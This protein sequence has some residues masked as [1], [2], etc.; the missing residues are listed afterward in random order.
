LEFA[1]LVLLGL[2]PVWLGALIRA[3][4]GRDWLEYLGGYL[5]GG[6][7]LLLA[8][9]TVGPLL[10]LV[11]AS[12]FGARKGASHFPL[13]GWYVLAIL[14]VCISSAGLFGFKAGHENEG[15]LA[16]SAIWWISVL[17]IGFSVILW[18]AISAPN[19]VR[20]HGAADVMRQDEHDFVR[21]Y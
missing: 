13:K 17:V 6:E 14:L 15:G 20:E 11:V 21:G 10:Y 3:G 7:A 5:T 16:P 8:T 2:M 19:A 9:A 1:F 18:F 4:Q 12:D